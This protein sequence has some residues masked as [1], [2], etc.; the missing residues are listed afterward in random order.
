MRIEPGPRLPL[1]MHAVVRR[2]ARHL[3]VR[4]PAP[5]AVGRTV[6]LV[7]L[8]AAAFVVLA[9]LDPLHLRRNAA[10]EFPLVSAPPPPAVGPL[11]PAVAAETWS[12]VDHGLALAELLPPGSK[13]HTA[14]QRYS[15][16]TPGE[17]LADWLAP[18]NRLAVMRLDYELRASAEARRRALQQRGNLPD[19]DDRVRRLAADIADALTSGA[20]MGIGEVALAVRALLASGR[21]ARN[22]VALHLGADRLVAALPGLQAGELA[23][24]LAALGELAAS[25]GL[26]LQQVRE[27]GLRLL[28][29]TVDVDDLSWTRR[30]PRLLSSATPPA[31]VADAGRFLALGPA[32]GLPGDEVLL[33]RLLLEAHLQERRDLRN[34]MPDLL[35]A[36]VYGFG[37]LMEPGERQELEDRLR[38]WRPTSL[39]PDYVALQQLAWSRTPRQA[40]FARFQLEL[41]RVSA[42]PTPAAIGD[43][44][45]LLLCLATNFAAP[46]ALGEHTLAD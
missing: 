5:S 12:V 11:A 20:P 45:A 4:S 3:Q 17:Q 26:H 35:T 33:A 42:L 21:Y 41:R 40:G 16:R 13:L 24:A 9:L 38:I 23:S 46:G 29:E 39:V 10:G 18:V 28:H 7:L 19:V 43:R 1:A 14:C 25:T 27:H 8:A 31:Q 34:E 44:A 30:R 15:E 32:F 2:A 37:D 36:L 22:A 6:A